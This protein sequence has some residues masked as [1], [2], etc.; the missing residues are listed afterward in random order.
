MEARADGLPTYAHYFDRAHSFAK[1]NRKPVLIL[2]AERD[3]IYPPPTMNPIFLKQ[4]PKAD[5]IVAKGQAHCFAD[6]G[7]EDSFGQA[8]VNWL[9]QHFKP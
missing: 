6:A 2:A 5:C 3:I 4:F 8:L 7:W 9:S 1:I